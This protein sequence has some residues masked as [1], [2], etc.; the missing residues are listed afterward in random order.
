[1]TRRTPSPARTCG[2]AALAAALAC[3]GPL[4]PADD[5]ATG[6]LT[7]P[8]TDP[9]PDPTTG[10]TPTSAAPT[11]GGASTGPDGTTGSGGSSTGSGSTGPAELPTCGNGVVDPGEACDLGVAHNWNFGACTAACEHARC[12]DGFI[13]A[14]VETCDD[15]D[16]NGVGYAECD[17]VS[18]HLGPHCGDGELA[19][20]EEC[21]GT[22]QDG[23]GEVEGAD[24]PCR[25]GCTWDGRIVFVTSQTFDGD[26]GGLGGADLRCQLAAQAAGLQGHAGYRAWLSDGQSSPL[27]RLDFGPEPV[28]LLDGVRVAP[29]LAG[30]IAPGPEVGIRVTE[31]RTTILGASVWT[32][33]AV[34]GEVFSA[35][36]HCGG[37]TAAT[38]TSARCGLNAVPELP[39]DTW[40]QWHAERAWTSAFARECWVPQRLYCIEGVES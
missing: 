19:P 15:G 30:L 35:A 11:T 2:R 4:A 23:A 33:T 29:D 9:A 12:G 32:N 26:L 34:D 31:L 39:A 21:D 24:V 37:W 1:M 3:S 22:G 27:D 5:T 17:P 18:C 14:G 7:D 40:A 13:F 25:P 10:P 6:P 28:V 8:G 36:D 20:Q 38:M 16:D